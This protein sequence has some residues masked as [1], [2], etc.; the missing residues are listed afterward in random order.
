MKKFACACYE[1]WKKLP[2]W[3]GM[4]VVFAIAD[5]LFFIIV[6]LVLHLDILWELFH[7]PFFIIFDLLHG[8]VSLVSPIHLGATYGVIAG[9]IGAFILGVVIGAIKC[10]RKKEYLIMALII[11]IVIILGLNLLGP[12][13]CIRTMNVICTVIPGFEAAGFACIPFAAFLYDMPSALPAIRQGVGDKMMTDMCRKLLMEFLDDDKKATPILIEIVGDKSESEFVRDYAIHTLGLINDPRAVDV[14]IKLLENESGKLRLVAAGALSRLSEIHQDDR[15][16]AGPSLVRMLTADSEDNI[17]KRSIISALGNI[18]AASSVEYLIPLLKDPE[19][20]IRSDTAK[21]LGEIKDKKAFIPL[22]EAFGSE[23]HDWVKLE[24]AIALA[25]LGDDES[26][27]FLLEE[28]KCSKYKK[29]IIARGLGE[30]GNPKAIKPLL[31]EYELLKGETSPMY[32][33][34]NV[35]IGRSLIILGSSKGIPIV[36]RYLRGCDLYIMEI[37]Q[38]TLDNREKWLAREKR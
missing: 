33:S 5:L 22:K 28:L 4:G 27:E 30:I 17:G 2:R 13:L 38:D 31:N 16:R 12:P 9:L 25:K 3:L 19:W 37:A 11:V 8:L 1:R 36:K 20:L 29:D 24:T 15:D 14:L 6:V 32:N 18:K 34:I 26:F 10:K 35:L 23:K 21:T 7:S